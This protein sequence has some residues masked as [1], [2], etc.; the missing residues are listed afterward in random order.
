[1]L[2]GSLQGTDE[3]SFFREK[4]R[5]ITAYRSISRSSLKFKPS[6]RQRENKCLVPSRKTMDVLSALLPGSYSDYR[7]TFHPKP[8]ALAILNVFHA[9]SQRHYLN[10]PALI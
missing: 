4:H 1:M 2:K 10:I 3:P 5:R 7:F 6:R 8:P 9:Y